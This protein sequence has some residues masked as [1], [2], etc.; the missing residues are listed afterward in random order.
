MGASGPLMEVVDILSDNVNVIVFFKVDES[1]VS[2][3][4]EGLDEVAAALVVET[5]Y[6]FGVTAEAIGRSNLHNGIVFPETV[7]V[8]ERLTA[9]FGAD[10]GT[11]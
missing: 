2:G 9:G 6:K 3:V 4:G 1:A 10:A 7:G 5:V 8:A 11:C